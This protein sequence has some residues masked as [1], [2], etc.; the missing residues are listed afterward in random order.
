MREA[1]F[2]NQNHKKWEE[3]ENI[4][5]EKSPDPDKLAELFIQIT[6][7]LAFSLTQYPDSKTT[8]YL[9]GLASQVHQNVYRTKKERK[10]RP[11]QFWKYDLPLLIKSCHKYLLYSFIIFSVSMI[12]GAVSTA[13]DDTFVRLILGDE[14]VNMTLENIDRN[15]PMAVYKSM[16]QTDMFLRITLNNIYVSFLAFTLGIL[17]PLGT[18][19][20]LFRNGLMLGAFQYFFYQQGLFVDSFLSIWIHGTLEISAIIIAGAAGLVIANSIMF[21]GTF[22]RLDSFRQGTRKGV[23]IVVGLIPI[24]ILAGFLESFVTRYTELPEILK[25]LI[26]LV[27]AFFIIFY[28]IIYPNILSKR[29]TEKNRI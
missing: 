3:F 9:N 29:G 8:F 2:I 13:H 11:L 18:P 1:A 19:Y 15:D 26:I 5:S 25:A 24:F 21:P 4:L 14:Y 12:I 7:D 20:I 27:S 17:I 10:N 22:T 28:F 16:N 23:K 6:D